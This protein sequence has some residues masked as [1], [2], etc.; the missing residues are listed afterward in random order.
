MS[1]IQSRTI[2]SRLHF[3]Q[4]ITQTVLSA[5]GEL[6]LEMATQDSEDSVDLDEDL[7]ETL[8]DRAA[9]VLQGDFVTPEEHAERRSE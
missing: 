8:D 9:D 3:A 5:D 2:R 7:A 6:L 1:L 4:R